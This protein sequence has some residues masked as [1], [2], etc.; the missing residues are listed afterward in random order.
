[1]TQDTF[2]VVNKNLREVAERYFLDNG[3]ISGRLPV[4][5]N[6]MLD[7]IVSRVIE[8]A[9]AQQQHLPSNKL[10]QQLT[11]YLCLYSPLKDY[12]DNK[13]AYLM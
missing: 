8:S 4:E 7:T 11:Q 13:I 12:K 1:M 5:Q 3:F 6:T 2:S 10:E 9:A